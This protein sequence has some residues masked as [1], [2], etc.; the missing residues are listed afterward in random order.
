[1]H[2]VQQMGWATCF[3]Q[4]QIIEN[5]TP[6]PAIRMEITLCNINVICSNQ[7]MILGNHSSKVSVQSYPQR[8]DKS[9]YLKRRR[10]LCPN[11]P[12]D[13][14]GLMLSL[15]TVLLGHLEVET[16]KKRQ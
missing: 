16:L 9:F 13:N 11:S 10:K 12:S 4:W 14:H 3:I 5:D 2:F 1:M 15:C 8:E 7:R 6:L